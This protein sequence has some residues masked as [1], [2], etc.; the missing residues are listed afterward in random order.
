ML[1]LPAESLKIAAVLSNLLLWATAPDSGWLYSH[2]V[3]I[4]HTD[5]WLWM[6]SPKPP[7]HR[8]SPRSR[9]PPSNFVSNLTC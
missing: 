1:Y 8:L 5:H 7:Q 2:R 9:G 3:F 6:Q 4:A